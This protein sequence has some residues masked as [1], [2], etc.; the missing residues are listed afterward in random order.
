[1]PG[2]GMMR[3]SLLEQTAIPPV[4][5]IEPSDWL[6]SDTAGAIALGG[7]SAVAALV[8]RILE[9]SQQRLEVTPELVLTGA[10][11]GSIQGRLLSPARVEP[12][13]VIQGLALLANSSKDD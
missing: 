11:A 4:D 5:T 9:Q 1:M 2:F 7:V 10:D 3:E 12:D 6:A 8:D 13:L